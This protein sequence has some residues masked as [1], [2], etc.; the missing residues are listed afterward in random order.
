M[1]LALGC[2]SLWLVLANVLAS[3]PRRDRHWVGFYALIAVGIPI[4]GW[5]TWT[6]GPVVG[7][8]VL[9]GAASML[10][11]PVL[12]LLRRFRHPPAGPAE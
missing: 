10:R 5:V 9:A 12:H 1:T 6:N 7:L 11:W 8:L 4:L 3:V 2:A